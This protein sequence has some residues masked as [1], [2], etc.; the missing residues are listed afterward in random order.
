MS[1]TAKGGSDLRL[2]VVPGWEKL[3]SG[4]VHGD[5]SDVAV[6]ADDNV[7]ILTRFDPRVIVY[8]R[9]GE[10][11]REWGNDFLSD[12]PHGIS[13]GPDGSVYVVDLDE[14]VVVKCDPIGNRLAELGVR[15]HASDT[16]YR[17]HDLKESYQG[18]EFLKA[19]L[20][21][22]S[23]P[24]EPFNLPT[25]VCV[26]ESGDLFVTD[27]YGNARVHRFR[28]NGELV[29]SWGEP[30]VGPGEFHLPHHV[31]LDRR[32]RLLVCDRENDR[33]QLFSEDGDYLEEWR[34]VQRPAAAVADREGHVYVAEIPRPRG[35]WSWGNG[36]TAAFLPGRVS[37]LD[38][39]TGAVLHRLGLERSEDPCA[40]GSFAAP[41]GIAIDST[42]AVYVAEVTHS[43]FSF[44]LDPV[45]TG[46]SDPTACHTLQKL[47]GV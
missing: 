44:L 37:I 15:G 9:A 4:Y 2:E 38:E 43:M 42:G 14:H 19:S 23:R 10:F 27:G 22:I 21:S 45:E 3:P 31:S 12:S 7:Y 29:L 30:G 46:R 5:V 20:E 41:H 24:G 25:A 26:A 11:L 34:D 28:P 8:D 18:G 1:P 17:G 47:I 32:G 39:S 16:G 33:I 13:L 6:D 40:P 35:D 36:T